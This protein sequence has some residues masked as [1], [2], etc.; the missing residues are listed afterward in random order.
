[1]HQV[2]Q[3]L[4]DRKLRSQWERRPGDEG[5]RLLGCR[6]HGAAICS[7][8][9]RTADRKVQRSHRGDVA[10]HW[11][12]RYAYPP[13]WPTRFLGFLGF[14]GTARPPD[15]PDF[16]VYTDFTGFSG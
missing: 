15:L 6:N 11:P 2:V 7:S 14:P 10:T 9:R 1:M 13:A 12:D 5:T 4:L 16:R 3:N 8:A